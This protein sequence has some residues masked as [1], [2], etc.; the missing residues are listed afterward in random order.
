VDEEAFDNVAEVIIAS[1][2]EG[3]M[4]V[5]RDGR[6]TKANEAVADLWGVS[7][8]ELVG[9]RWADLQIEV[10]EPDGGRAPVGD[11]P[12]LRALRGEIVRGTLV[13]VVRRDGTC[14][15]AEVNAT[16]LAE[17]GGRDHGALSTYADV[18]ERVQRERRMRHEADSDP[19]TG[20]AN[21]RA[22]ERTLDTAVERAR[23]DGREVAVLLLD[24]DGFKMLNDRWGHLAGDRALRAVARR[25]QR[26]VR[27]RDL[28]ARNG[29]DEFVI[30]LP[31]LQPGA[32]IA[33]ECRA[34]VEAALSAPVRFE[35]G[36]T[37]LGAAI[38]AATF[39][40]HGADGLSL[41]AHADRQMYA[42]K[43][44]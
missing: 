14:I 24:L 13:Q 37:T 43:P 9:S 7:L 15:W 20:L 8:G 42:G 22:L 35:G 32:P 4:V 26:C 5:D 6:I 30:V 41:L 17:P 19:L 29:G 36:S 10:Y 25:L 18:T 1:L 3:L 23:R 44:R 33:R 40:H 11:A 16:P 28:V 2:Q 21:R 27:E 38:G 39:P 34:R 31:D 12:V